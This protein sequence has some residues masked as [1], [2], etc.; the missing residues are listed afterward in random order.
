MAALAAAAGAQAPVPSRDTRSAEQIMPLVNQ[1]CGACHAVPSPEVLPKESW[2]RVIRNMAGTMQERTGRTHLTEAQLQDIIALYYGSAPAQL[3]KLPYA[4]DSS[5]AHFIVS[6]IGAHSALPF[7]THLNFVKLTRGADAEF[8][9]CDGEAQ[10]LLLL[11][12]SRGRW[13]EKPLA[14]ITI[15]VH[16]DVVDLDRDGDQD[17]LVADLGLFPPL[18]SLVGKLFLL[19]QVAPGKYEKEL[20]LDGVGRLSDARAVDLDTDGDLDIAVAVFGGKNVGGIYWL[21]NTGSAAFRKHDLLEIGGAINVSPA[22]L[23]A[24]GKP[25]LV[26]LVAQEHE[27][28]VAFVNRGA[29]NFEKGVI[30]RAPH[31]MYGSTSMTPVDLDQDGDVDVLFTNGD[32]FDEQTDPKPYHGVQWLENKGALQFE[33]HDIG[34]LYGA[35]SAAVGDLDRDG[36]LDV[37]VGSWGIDWNDARR[38]TLAWYENDGRQNFKPHGITT[39]PPGIVSIQLQDLN[40]DGTLDIVA[41]VLRMD[42]MRREMTAGTTGGV[43]HRKP[44]SVTP[45]RLSRV[46]V[47][48]N[49]L[50]R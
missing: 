50:G 33:F 11:S 41:G 46:L 18:E 5:V 24:D 49:H 39:R 25:D 9:V 7:V 31:P 47:F 26:S 44:T 35:A 21:E 37:V 17:I 23:N 48:E 4:E 40:G 34:R 12:R 30:A 16:T 42:L 28:V 20:L 38:H 29:G 45:E 1:Y 32:A 8:L 22:D 10:R 36:D 6:D 27:M 19:R 3:P 2:P 14:E 43:G 15:P 13:T